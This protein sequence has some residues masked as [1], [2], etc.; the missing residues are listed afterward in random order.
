MIFLVE[1]VNETM[2]VSF[3]SRQVLA[4]TVSGMFQSLRTALP[5]FDHQDASSSPS[6]CNNLPVLSENRPAAFDLHHLHSP[7]S[8]ANSLPL[9]AMMGGS[10]NG[11]FCDASGVT[12]PVEGTKSMLPNF[13]INGGAG[14]QILFSNYNFECLSREVT[15]HILSSG[16]LATSE[17]SRKP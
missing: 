9:N 15:G 10:C 4:R 8:A 13:L 1:L 2:T 14:E 11:G 7:L 16:V 12:T 3:F 5:N 17:S 6:T